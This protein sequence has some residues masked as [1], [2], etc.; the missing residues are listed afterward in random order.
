[1][2]ATRNENLV[3]DGSVTSSYNGNPILGRLEGPCADIIHPTRNGRLY[4]DDL[5]AKVFENDIVK[6]Y[7]ECGGIFGELGHPTD[8]SETDMEKICVCMPKPPVKGEDGRLMGSWDILNTP[9]GRILKCLCDYGFKMGISS[10]GTGDVVSDFSGHES[11]DPDTYQFEAFDVV[12]LPAVKSARLSLVKESLGNKTLAQALT[13]SLQ[14]SS[15]EDRKIMA[16]TLDKL[17]IAYNAQESA[18]IES[19]EETKGAGDS[20]LVEKL[21]EALR[22]Q[23]ELRK[24]IATLNEQLSACNAREVK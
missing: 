22:E 9:N 14:S 18:Y 15:E 17:N 8:R 23:V 10:R 11:V 2:V 5:W 3:Y 13:E 21:Q 4:S 20:G 19:T 24:R 16:E 7:F 1:M 12:L 6:E